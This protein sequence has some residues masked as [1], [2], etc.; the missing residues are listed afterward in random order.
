MP[1][2]EFV[3][4]ETWRVCTTASQSVA[5][6]TYMKTPEFDSLTLQ[7]L[8]VIHQRSD[9]FITQSNV[10]TP[11]LLFLTIVDQ[12]TVHT[13]HCT[14]R[15]YEIAVNHKYDYSIFVIQSPDARMSG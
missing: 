14:H 1:Q 12:C 7:I 2:E 15:Q 10:L 9:L 5:L 6:G 4:S 13:P 3:Q 11:L 8:M